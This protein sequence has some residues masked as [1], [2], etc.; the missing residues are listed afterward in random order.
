MHGQP[1]PVAEIEAYCARL[2]DIIQV[3]GKIKLIQVY[4]VVRKPHESWVEPLDDV[5]LEAIG[6]RIRRNT[7]VPVEIFGGWKA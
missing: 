1:P 5:E 6:A 2:N 3:G 4:T 7:Q